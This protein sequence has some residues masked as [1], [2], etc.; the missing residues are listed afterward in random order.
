[1]PPINDLRV[2]RLQGQSCPS[3]D[4]NPAFGC[5]RNRVSK[6]LLVSYCWAAFGIQRSAEEVPRVRVE[7]KEF[8]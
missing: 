8:G 6:L 5:E 3:S 4:K 7:Q 2:P 1:V